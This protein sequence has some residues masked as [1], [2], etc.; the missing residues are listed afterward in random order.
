[1]KFAGEKW[2]ELTEETKAPYMKLYEADKR[3][4][5]AQLDELKKKGYFTM[6]DGTKSSA[7]QLSSA[8]KKVKST[9]ATPRNENK[10][11]TS[12]ALIG[13]GK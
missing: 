4:Y 3:R 9:D 11:R 13:K 1:M 8:K 5:E 12:S 6:S 10:K 7:V 2:R